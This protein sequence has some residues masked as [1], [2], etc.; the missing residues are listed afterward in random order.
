MNIDCKQD[1]NKIILKLSG[2]LDTVTSLKLAS[3]EQTISN[4]KITSLI[5]DLK[6]LEYLSSAGLRVILKFQKIM[7]KKGVMEVIN[8]N[9]FIME[10][11]DMTGFTEILTIK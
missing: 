5:L 8:V 7:K 1:N 10:I 6:K 9:S 4:D 2:R 3:F 11:F